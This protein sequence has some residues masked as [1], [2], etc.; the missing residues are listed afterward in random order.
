MRWCGYLI[1]LLALISCTKN[2]VLQKGA[3]F[4]QLDPSQIGIHFEN[5]L[6]YTEDF[7]VYLYRNFYN[8][9]GT[10]LADFNN[11]GYLDL[12]FCGNQV[13]NALYLGDG[14]FNFKDVTN[15][16]KVASP[17]AWVTGVSVVDINQDGWNDIYVCKSGD[18]GERNR[19]NEL[20]VNTGT[21][22]DGIPVFE[23]QAKDFGIDE[24]SFSVHAQFF[25]YDLDG[26]LDMY[27]SSSTIKPTEMYVDAEKGIRTK[28]KSGGGD[29]L[30][31]NNNNYYTDVTEESGIYSSSIGFGLGIALSDLN[32][33]GWP[34]IYV[35]NDY[36]EK[37]YLY[38]NNQ[39]GTFTESIDEMLGEISLGAMGVD[40]ADMNHDGYPEIFVTEMMPEMEAR[41][42]TKAVFET[43]DEYY[44]KYINGYHRQFARN[45]FQ[46]N[47]GPIS[48]T[49]N[50]VS[51]SEISRYAGVSATDWSWGVQMV[52]FDNDANNEIFITNG[53]VKDL[54]DQDYVESNFDPRR[55]RATLKEKGAVIK[56]LIDQMPM[57]PVSNYLYKLNENLQYTDVASGWGIGQ[58]GY[59]NGATY[60]DIDNDGDLDLVVNNIN[61]PPYVY[62]NTSNSSENHFINLTIKNR[63]AATDIGAKVTL[64]AGGKIF[65]QELFPIRG[66]MSAVDDR[67]N[68]G[69]GKS[70]VIDTLQ[71]IWSDGS[72][73]IDT[74]VP[75]DTF[76][77]CQQPNKIEK[78]ADFIKKESKPA[79]LHKL[80]DNAGMDY[81]HVENPY[82]DFERDPLLFHMVSNEGP[83]IAVGDVNGDGLDDFYIG[84]AKDSPGKIFKQIAD[85]FIEMSSELFESDKTSEDVGSLFLDIDDDGDN[86]LVVCSGGYEFSASS[87]ALIDRL[88]TNE[89]R[90][91]FSKIT[92]I[93]P[94]I[95]PG[96]TSVVRSADFDQDGDEDLFFGSRFMA[97]SYGVSIQSFLLENTGNG[98]FEDVTNEKAT[99]LLKAGMVADA[100][101][102]D[103]DSDGDQ[104]LIVVGEWMPIK[105]YENVDGQLHYVN[106]DIG[107]NASNGLWN[108]LQKADLD[109]DGRED[110]VVGNLGDN[111][112]FK[113]S[114][115]EPVRM[116]VNDFDSNGDLD[117]IITTYRENKQYPVALKNDL[118]TQI[119]ALLRKY[120]KH[121]DYKEQSISDI[122]AEDVINNSLVNE[123]FVNESVVLWN[124]GGKFTKQNLPMEAQFSSVY[125]IC[126]VD[127]DKDGNKDLVLGGNQQFA[128]PQTG[129]Y[130]ASNGLV[131]KSTGKRD[132][133]VLS[134]SCSGLHLPGQIRDIKLINI[135]GKQHLLFAM[136]N[137]SLRV[138]E[139]NDEKEK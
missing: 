121:S 27:L 21:N 2:N 66:A 136:N 95:K 97:S 124:E 98:I 126:V 42:K 20:F 39:D 116:Y 108:V 115:E 58:K 114:I 32:K 3:V 31:Q 105:V 102:S 48:N 41:L 10:A 117:Q 12:F 128:K 44:R 59:S 135:R 9:A 69:L 61:S 85:G 80:I 74:N 62:R 37:D 1:V 93:Y 7:N 131:L 127:L 60:G 86:D 25:D 89:G 71:I 50:K 120:P 57:V 47:N 6:T 67:L 54:L 103:Y 119:P 19:R 109:N 138:Y 26:D 99:D 16:S 76:I 87:Y 133:N 100:V 107:L 90:G 92:Q 43:W 28:E 91:N 29:K 34:D 70:E 22:I 36:F 122:F 52:D 14:K 49:N 65:Y 64:K 53:I 78:Q 55:I 96:S 38:I 82:I 111:T 83:K 77:V 113:A 130:N 23:E 84:G 79:L 17:N 129:I 139:I 8:G 134:S 35:A 112:F 72:E 51:F 11:D 45:S 18:P 137:D 73:K 104:D 125:A 68:F 132:F 63:K 118:T 4:E 123:V 56:E 110:L 101:W 75:V 88:Y 81:K 13:N 46:L 30:F 94:G 33:D 5:T 106:E 24:L 15:I 40:I